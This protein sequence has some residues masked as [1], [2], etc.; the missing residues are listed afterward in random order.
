MSSANSDSFFFLIWIPFAYFSSLIAVVRTSKTMLS[1]NVESGHPCLVS[2]DRGNAFSFSLLSMMLLWVCYIWPWLCWGRFSLCTFWKVLIIN[3]CW[4]LS[5]F[6]CVYWDDHIAFILH[7]AIS[8]SRG[9]SQPRDR[10]QV[11]CIA[12]RHFNLWATREAHVNV[13]HHSN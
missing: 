11:S 1:K 7:F 5:G 8:F 10:T 13:V 12:G 4:I 2:D 6:F 3:W 9:S